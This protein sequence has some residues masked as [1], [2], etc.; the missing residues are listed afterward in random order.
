MNYDVRINPLA[1]KDLDEIYEYISFND[2]KINA[3]K[4]I[5]KLIQNVLT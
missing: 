2:S 4:V 1:E 5:D 3:E